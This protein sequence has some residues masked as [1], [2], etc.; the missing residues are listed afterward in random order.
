MRNGK[1]RWASQNNL[2][3]MPID[4]RRSSLGNMLV[5]GQQSS[6]GNP[7]LDTVFETLPVQKDLRVLKP[8]L[9]VDAWQTGRR[10][11]IA[12][13]A[14]AACPLK[15]L[16]VLSGNK[17]PRTAREA[18]SQ[19]LGEQGAS[20]SAYG[21]IRLG[22]C[23]LSSTSRSSGGKHQHQQS[24]QTQWS[25]AVLVLRQNYLLEYSASADVAS[26]S[27]RGF[28]HLQYAKCYTNT[29]FPDALELHFYGSPCAK[30]DKRVLMIRV[31]H[32]E[33]RDDWKECLNRASNLTVEDLYEFDENTDALGKG[34]YASVYTARRKPGSSSD[35]HNCALKV[36]DKKQYWR[37]VVKGRER[38]DTLV[39]ETSVQATGKYSTG[40]LVVS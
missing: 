39:R 28:A 7:L 5:H 15:V 4:N 18:S 20:A 33:E 29:D 19:F 22:E 36:F 26:T 11:L 13:A 8:I 1:S 31:Q 2:Q 30:S 34:S 21:C 17:E 37:M 25:S 27:P 16:T 6:P 38:A 32:R 14:M 23:L 3:A 10:Y 12:P 9:S 40:R 35:P 24:T